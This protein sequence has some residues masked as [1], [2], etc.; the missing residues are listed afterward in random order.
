MKGMP[1]IN[2]KDLMLMQLAH[3]FITV[4]NYTPIV[5]RGI[6]NEIW[7]ENTEAPY[8]IVRINAN[9]LHNNEQL[10]F[11]LFKIKNIVKQIKKKTLSL[12]VKTLNIL[13]DVG[14]NVKTDI[15]KDKKVESIIIDYNKSIEKNKKLNSLYPALKD[16][17]VDDK[18]GIDF[19]IN[20]TNDINSKTEKESKEYE[21]VFKK[22]RI[23][24]TY[25]LIAINV[26]MFILTTIGRMT[27]RFD[28]L[29]NFA[30]YKGYVVNGEIYRLIT[31]TFLHESILHLLM[32][33]YALYI[34]GGQV[35]SFIGKPKFLTIY[36]F[37]GITG[38]LLSCIVNGM[39]SWSLGASGAIFGLMG[40]LI[41]FGYHYRLYLDNALKTQIIPLVILNLA[42]GF[43]FPNIDNGAHI[44][45]LVGGLFSA[46]AL[47]VEN[48][49][50]KTDSIN[51]IICSVLL[52][53]FLCYLVFF[54]R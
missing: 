29:T 35:E 36:F 16:N 46:M 6:Q 25:A 34:I 18:N 47:G 10:D 48:K 3:Y 30:L 12:S 44:G 52:F 22:K 49:T 37:S 38:S 20:V 32:N 2:K 26:I 54:A 23:T 53:G 8:K 14:T 43:I 24:A 4:E 19:I 31:S 11:D 50:T 7:L 45:G 42:I 27:G 51:G 28:L 9:Y 15:N 41:Y 40:A 33:M 13:L 21:R 39:N 1:E 17:V 5:V